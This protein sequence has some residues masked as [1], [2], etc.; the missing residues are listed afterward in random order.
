M[1]V[2]ANHRDYHS[3]LSAKSTNTAGHQLLQALLELRTRAQADL[4][5]AWRDPRTG[6]RKI[7]PDEKHLRVG[8]KG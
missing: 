1:D 7:S 6:S 3:C 8:G 5:S 4:V 2:G